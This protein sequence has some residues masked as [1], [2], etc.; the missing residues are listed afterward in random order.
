[1]YGPYNWVQLT[2]GCLSHLRKSDCVPVSGRFEGLNEIQIYDYKFPL[3]NAMP[4][5]I[6][7]GF[8]GQQSS[9]GRQD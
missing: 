3:D 6:R 7:I 5:P 8:L 2:T 9:V 4:V 1:M